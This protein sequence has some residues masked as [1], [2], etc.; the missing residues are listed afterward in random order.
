MVEVFIVDGITHEE[1]EQQID[2][3]RDSIRVVNTYQ[4]H[5]KQFF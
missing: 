1:V 4:P 3:F 2:R 5:G